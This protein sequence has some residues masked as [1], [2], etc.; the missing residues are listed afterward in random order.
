MCWVCWASC[1][2]LVHRQF[3]PCR[4]A[5]RM[6]CSTGCS[7]SGR[8][9]GSTAFR[10]ASDVTFGYTW[11]SMFKLRCRMCTT[12]S[13]Q[14]SL[15]WVACGY[16]LP[17]LSGVRLHVSFYTQ[18]RLSANI[19]MSH[20]ARCARRDDERIVRSSGV[21]NGSFTTQDDFDDC[22]IT[23][24]GREAAETAAKRVRISEVHGPQNV[25]DSDTKLAQTT[26]RILS[27]VCG[28]DTAP[29]KIHCAVS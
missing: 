4:T 9:T 2:A 10:E 3:A 14:A 5:R 29:K 16:A 23:T 13:W 26:A 19:V 12:S 22:A 15:K 6:C 27:H 1:G 17:F 25:A 11:P 8:S 20:V 24:A 28:S 18:C 7:A 21:E